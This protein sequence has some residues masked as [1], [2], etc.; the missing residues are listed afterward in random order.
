MELDKWQKEI[1]EA[2][3]N[4]CINSGRQVGKSTAVA[5]KAGE[6]AI[7]NPKKFILIVSVT[8]DQS[9]RFISII[10]QYI[11]EKFTKKAFKRT[12]LKGKIELR[13]GS[14]IRCKPIG[15]TGF[16]VLGYTVDML[17]ADEAAFMPESVWNALTPM[18]LT[19]GG[20]LIMISTPKISEGYFYNAY[21]K[22]ELGFKTFHINSEEVAD[23][24]P[25]PY[26]SKMWSIL[27][28]DKARMTKSEYARW[29]L[30]IF[31]DQFKQYYPEEVL[32]HLNKIQRKPFEQG[33][34]YIGV[35]IARYGGDETTFEIFRKLDNGSLIQIENIAKQD[36][37]ITWT[38]AKITELNKLYDFRRIYIDTGG[39]GAGVF[40]NL[41]EIDEVKRKVVD[42]NAAKKAVEYGSDARVRRILK[43]DMH[44]NL[45]RLM[46]NNKVTILDDDKVLLS[47]RSVLYEIDE[48]TKQMKIYGRYTHIAEGMVRGAWCAKENIN[49]L[50]ISYI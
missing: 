4:L 27:N 34:Y 6:Y 15:T 10:T 2:E 47:L 8:E 20:A 50:W 42:M 23:S 28:A 16:G 40:D 29:Y 11:A 22:P 21:T 1:I 25:E 26:K 33:D 39:L 13:N 46:E 19:T 48:N 31:Q 9:E 41:L 43:E 45:L 3:G 12:P 44:A 32:E 35:D 38:T 5:I 7:K 49:K 24:R 17:I 18:L 30:A 14:V 36:T 37:S